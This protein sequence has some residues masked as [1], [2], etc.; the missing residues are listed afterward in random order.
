MYLTV[1]VI[2]I[3]VDVGIYKQ[4]LSIIWCCIQYDTDYDANSCYWNARAYYVKSCN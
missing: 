2:H 1:M 4:V 3:G